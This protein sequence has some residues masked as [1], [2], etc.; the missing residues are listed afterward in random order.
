MDRPH[1]YPLGAVVAAI[2]VGFAICAA[3]APVERSSP[4]TEFSQSAT[5]PESSDDSTALTASGDASLEASQYAA[6]EAAYSQ[7][8][9]VAE[10]HDGVESENVI[11]PLLGLG[12]TLARSGHHEEAVHRLQRALA[13]QR[14][15]YGLFD[16]RQMDTL[17]TLAGSLTALNRT[18]EAQELM[19]YRA[20]AAERAYGEGDPRVV[21]SL[22]DLGNWYAETGKTPEARATFLAAMNNIA[23]RLAGNHPLMVEP[24]RGM[25]R[26]Y[27]L[28]PSYPDR[29]RRPPSP[30]GCSMVGAECKPPFRMD[31]TGKLIVE[32]REL[33]REGEY[34]LQW[35]LRLLDEDPNASAQ[36]RIETLIQMGDW[37]QIKKSPREALPYYQHAW[38]LIRL[39]PGQSGS[40][41]TALDQ[42]LRVY[43]PTPQIVANVPAV[44][45]EETRSH[46]VQVE[47]TVAADGSVKDARIVNHDTRDRYAQDILSAVRASRFR[48]KLVDG[49]AVATPAVTYREVFWT[50]TPRT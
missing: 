32:P 26:A 35:A 19:F 46:H 16:L 9:R 43:Y 6:A 22:C 40:A 20:R 31:K 34:A 14:A 36:T 30:P 18:D 8:L 10:Q 27:M 41:A 24:L 29:W 28:R 47:F 21:P 42:P 15:Q 12:N 37:Y 50:A 49:E 39:A 23:A 25:A 45:P 13:L 2:A 1:P 4:L 7:A 33:N 17:K 44:A 48:P 5:A 3:A 11:A 38:Q